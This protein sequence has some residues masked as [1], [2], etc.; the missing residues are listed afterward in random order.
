MTNVTP[1]LARHLALLRL[2]EPLDEGEI[3]AYIRQWEKQSRPITADDEQ[4]VYDVVHEYV[5][6]MAAALVEHEGQ[7]GYLC[8]VLQIAPLPATTAAGACAIPDIAAQWRRI[9]RAVET[10]VE[11]ADVAAITPSAFAQLVARVDA[12][13]NKNPPP[14][15][16]LSDDE[17]D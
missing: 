16:A 1:T 10:V 3:G 6:Q 12:L 13:E 4:R 9:T 17:E 2:I 15:L 5:R 8:R 14:L 7:A 11:R